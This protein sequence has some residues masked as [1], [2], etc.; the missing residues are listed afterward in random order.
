M[1]LLELGV[2]AFRCFRE[3]FSLSR[4]DPG[5]NLICGPNEAG[6]STLFAALAHGLLT[7]HR[8]SGRSVEE[9]RPWGTQLSPRIWMVVERGGQRWR[10]SKRFLD[11]RSCRL[12]R[13]DGASLQAVAE[14][15]AAEEML[16][17]LLGSRPGARG[18][19]RLAHW[20]IAELLW[21]PQG[22][23]REV[24]SVGEELRARL[25]AG[26]GGIALSGRET[27][28]LR[29]LEARHAAVFQEKRGAVRAGSELAKQRRGVEELAAE[30]A[31]TEAQRGLVD[32]SSAELGRVLEQE[33]AL[34]A[35]Q[36]ELQRAQQDLEARSAQLRH[37]HEA[38]DRAQG[39]VTRAR[40][41]FETADIFRERLG[42][43]QRRM[44]EQDVVVET[45]GRRQT[46]L[47]R[48]LDQVLLRYATGRERV[49]GARREV[50]ELE[51]RIEW[52]RVR[53]DLERLE[54]RE[55]QL[56]ELERRQ[57]ELLEAEVV[58]APTEDELAAAE[59]AWEAR[60]QA[61]VAGAVRLRVEAE[62]ELA[63][64][65][66]GVAATLAPGGV[67]VQDGVGRLSVRLPGVGRI[68]VELPGFDL[69]EAAR[70]EAAWQEVLVRHEVS[71]LAELRERRQA[72]ERRRELLDRL[73][74][75][76]A[77]LR[78]PGESAADL[79]A[80][81]ASLTTRAATLARALAQGAASPQ[82]AELRAAQDE[83][84]AGLERSLAELQESQAAL[85]DLR[86][87][88]GELAVVR[89]G[90][91]VARRTAQVELDEIVSRYGS[92]EGLLTRWREAR[93][94][95]DL[96]VDRLTELRGA[97]PSDVEV[98]EGEL[99]R[100]GRELEEL[101]SRLRELR[102]REVSCRTR[103]EDAR[104]AGLYDELVRQREALAR[105]ERELRRGERRARATRLLLSLA[106]HVHRDLSSGLA[107]PLAAE[108]GVA[109]ERVSARSGREV[110]LGEDL[111]LQGLRLQDAFNA[112]DGVR[113]EPE[114]DALSGGTL[115]QLG[116]LYRLA[117]G[118]M[119]AGSGR[120]AVV[121]D[122]PLG[123]TDAA[124]QAR[125]LEL[126]DKEAERLQILILTCH[127]ERY[128]RLTRAKVFELPRG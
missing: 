18:P 57:V 58:G 23:A 4:L 34:A 19:G 8:T 47:E 122:D 35:R 33:A 15:D 21:V 115:E 110:R 14:G 75:E 102:D 106:R 123:E 67:H 50:G 32:Q 13:A 124:R 51:R 5:L 71:E 41:A 69:E 72:A 74:A 90:A 42:A 54:E 62:R 22:G 16:R 107:A 88:G 25:R 10:I 128:A 109:L 126:L 78:K 77:R 118:R 6:K 48:E 65:S 27:D 53:E 125:L 82:G 64:E 1:I 11:Q 66:E 30:L 98:I 36:Q 99:G 85:E 117:L 20:A 40:S 116:L 97:V 9:L 76:A 60:L 63:L 86:R 119:L 24:P 59:R 103:L 45:L 49:A 29:R 56:A 55:A 121:L 104:G 46:Q 87:Q 83:A 38:L 80:A 127:P 114:L 81:K 91:E 7:N 95:F 96:A 37:Y 39:E 100:T 3:P 113:L 93:Q 68:T 120:L 44:R 73:E 84:R 61:R 108:L 92:P 111:A 112:G 94:Q 26:A 12:E 2:E 28:L 31:R 52:D 79:Q 105:A 17:D 101:A 89:Q 70:A 43:L